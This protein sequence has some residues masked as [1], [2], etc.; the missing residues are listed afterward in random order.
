VTSNETVVANFANALEDLAT[1][2]TI[3][4]AYGFGWSSGSNGGIGFNPWVLTKT[5]A[6]ANRNGFFLDLS[7]D[8][9]P[10]VG[11]GI[12]TGGKSW[13]IYANGS[14]SAAAYRSF[15]IGPVQAGGQLLIDMDNGYND[16]AGSAVGFTLRNG[17]A[18]NS[19]ADSTTGARLQ[20]YLA[21]GNT[22]YTIVDAAG[23]H[24]SGVPLTYAGMHL[25]FALGTN[26]S[27]TLTII[28][29]GSGSTNTI[30][31]TL[32]GAP[33]STLDSIAVFNNNAG[34]DAPHNV[35]FNSLSMANFTPIIYTI[36]I[37]SS[38]SGGGSTS[39]GGVVN[40][41]SNVTVCAVTNACYQFV[42]WTEGSNV[43]SSS[44]CYGFTASADRDLVANF[45]QI[46]YTITTS[47]S[48]PEGG[49]TDGD[50]SKVCG[51]SVTV[52]ATPSSGYNFVN[53]K[54]DD[55]PVSSSTNYTF[56]A[57]GNRDLVGNF[58]P[59][60]PVAAFSA[61]PTNGAAPLLVS[62]TD[63][64]SGTITNHF[65][66]F[67]DGNTSTAT[68][69]SHSY[70]TAGVYTVALIVSGP[71][72]SSATNR[73]NLITV[74]NAMRTP[75]TVSIV[76]PAN[77]MLYPTSTTNLIIA[78]VASATAND[79]GSISKI[80]FFA[81][82]TKLGETAFNPATNFLVHPT[83][84]VHTLTAV[85][86]DTLLATNLSNPSTITVGARNSPL[87]DW[88]VTIGGADKGAQFLTFEDDF[89]ASGFGIRLETF[90]LDD[91][92]GHW[93]FDAKGQVTGPFVEQTGGTTNWT[94][95]LLGTAASLKSVNGAVPTALGTFR[96]KGVP[97]T[98][99][100]DLSGTWTGLVTIVKSAATVNY[101]IS[102]NANDSAVFD[103][104]TSGDSGTVV[105]QLLV[106]SRNKVYAYVTFDGK[107]VRLSG[108]FS[109]VRHSLTLRGTDA[110]A[111]KIAVKL[112]K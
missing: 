103:I 109:A 101:V 60:A 106:T 13:G 57:S 84:G 17:D 71:G 59:A 34:P 85:A 69:P 16:V 10:H 7:T 41:G 2:D 35:F 39:G 77:G 42:N 94:G 92:L 22:D 104:A 18:T 26:D 96:W 105:G 15:A 6:D 79:G 82:G 89:S 36:N 98:T 63:A 99:F 40:C 33:S 31:G 20:F 95:T 51:S 52:N 62:F 100:P 75:P 86:T 110:T 97:A 44:L 23:A 54:E 91:V 58:V 102:S 19:P 55:S 83:L 64:S 28:T 70:S 73:V 107:Q 12:D 72:G 24:D 1:D 87:G 53:W 29:G 74:T 4:P 37:S 65:W 48:P 81:D 56:T 93:G 45:S 27:Y 66:S 3:G 108:A 61:S 46:N 76:R 47:S 8:N 50:G 112:F 111:E 14:N 38:P 78:V 43:V 67:G 88:E 32:G 68:S 80:E 25:I 9:L 30:S 11:P 49:T 21:G 90:G 5:S